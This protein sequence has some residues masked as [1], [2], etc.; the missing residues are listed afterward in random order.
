MLRVAQLAVSIVCAVPAVT[1]LRAVV[2]AWKTFT[3]GVIVLLA[4]IAAI[5]LGAA[6]GLMRWRGWS[7]WLAALAAS[8]Y[9]L[10]AYAS[11]R[12][13]EP[14]WMTVLYAAGGLVI[15]AWI[16]SPGV[17]RRLAAGKG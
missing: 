16:M 15:M 1:S 12:G 13:G 5:H 9:F 11:F 7:R 8:T 10:V 2:L 4:G 3:V 6:Y 17:T 14:K